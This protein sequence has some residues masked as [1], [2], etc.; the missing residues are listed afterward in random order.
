M[1]TQ[2]QKKGLP[3]LAWVGIG[4]GALILIIVLV[5]VIGGAYVF[6]KAK[7]VAGDFEK[8]PELAAARLVVKMHPELEE[9]RHDEAAGTITV[10]ERETGKEITASFKD[11]KEGKFSLIGKD[12]ETVT[13]DSNQDE[14]GDSFTITSDE[15]SYT[16]GSGAQAGEIP[17]WVPVPENETPISH[18]VMTSTD[19][20]S[21]A[22]ALTS[23][24]AFDD[25]AA[26]FDEALK[27]GG[28][29]VST[30]RYSGDQGDGG[31]ITANHAESAREIVVTIS[32]ENGR[33]AV[34]ITYSQKQQP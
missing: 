30:T 1:E 18:Q 27:S 3:A 33:S 13:F 8:N 26:F 23:G 15:G 5:M 6:N 29:Q 12:G 21:G 4:C 31:V 9:V 28:F 24:Q 16:V 17:D 25:L 19:G 34:A 14:S 22:L 11:I 10:R 2:Q 7:D 20:M 32:P